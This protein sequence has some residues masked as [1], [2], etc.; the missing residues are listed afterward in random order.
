MKVKR[1][2]I[3]VG[4]AFTIT[5]KNKVVC[6]IVH[7]NR[8]LIHIGLI[9]KP[10]SKIPI[11]WHYNKRSDYRNILPSKFTFIGLELCME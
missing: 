10:E 2:G 1:Y 9:F 7:V 3:H 11:G 8:T 5:N 4:K 6:Y